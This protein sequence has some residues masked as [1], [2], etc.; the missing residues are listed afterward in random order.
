MALEVKRT[1]Y[2]TLLSMWI[3]AMLSIWALGAE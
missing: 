3:T 2:P 1:L